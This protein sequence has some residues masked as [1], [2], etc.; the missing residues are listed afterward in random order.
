MV[1]QTLLETNNQAKN[2]RTGAPLGNIAIVSSAYENNAKQKTRIK[3]YKLLSEAQRIL[4]ENNVCNPRNGNPHRTRFCHARRTYL[5]DN[6]A[7]KL[8]GNDI[9]SEAAIGNVQTCGSVWSCPICASRIAV[10]KGKLVQK[11]LIYS[12]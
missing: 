6:I 2:A 5:A 3:R 11:A 12:E 1:T 8:N 9:Q 4:T 7:L 10:E